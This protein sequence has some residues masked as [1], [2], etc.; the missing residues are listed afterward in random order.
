MCMGQAPEPHRS[1]GVGRHMA[2]RGRFQ[3]D[4]L[5]T[6]EIPM[7]LLL[8]HWGGSKRE[9][10]RQFC[11]V[12]CDQGRWAGSKE[13]FAARRWGCMGNGERMCAGGSKAGARCALL[14]GQTRELA[15]PDSVCASEMFPY[16]NRVIR[17]EQH[18]PSHTD[19]SCRKEGKKTHRFFYS[20]REY[21]Q[22]NVSLVD[23][24][25]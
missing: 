9:L 15:S 2:T 6:G 23:K 5:A 25:R 21:F 3:R 17:C 14:S 18:L 10:G 20:S 1:A 16:R 24:L 22:Q 8:A 11:G 12:R 19:W 13:R 7:F 4:F